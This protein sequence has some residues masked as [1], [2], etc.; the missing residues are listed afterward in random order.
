MAIYQKN[1]WHFHSRENSSLDVTDAWGGLIAG[2]VTFSVPQ[3][4][5]QG[6]KVYVHGKIAPE[7]YGSLTAMLTGIGGRNVTSPNERT[8]YVTIEFNT[9]T[10]T[11]GERGIWKIEGLYLHD[12]NYFDPLT[13]GEAMKYLSPHGIDAYDWQGTNTIAPNA[14][15]DVI[16]D[17]TYTTD[18]AT[19]STVYDDSTSIWQVLPPLVET[20]CLLISVMIS[21]QYESGGIPLDFRIELHKANG[22]ELVQSR[23]M[24]VGDVKLEQETANFIIY[25]NGINDAFSRGGFKVKVFND[26]TKN[27]VLSKARVDVH[28]ISNPDF[29]VV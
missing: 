14:G 17:T 22:D 16:P 29:T 13:K 15:A 26:G 6:F 4:G 20:R 24:Y 19:G 18:I 27:L 10:S 25:T 1:L 28:C 3:R 7:N 8:D 11:D 12:Y 21:G 23:S 2:S 5:M 9:T